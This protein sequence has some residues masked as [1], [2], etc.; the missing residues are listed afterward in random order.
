MA[1]LTSDSYLRRWLTGRNWDV[2]HTRSC[3][4]KHAAWRVKTMPNGY[5][6][7]VGPGTGW[8]SAARSAHTGNTPLEHPKGQQLPVRNQSAN[9]NAA[10]CQQVAFAARADLLTVSCT[11]CRLFFPL[12]QTRRRSC[13]VWMC[14]GGPLPSHKCAGTWSRTPVL[15][16]WLCIHV[17]SSMPW[18]A[19]PN[20]LQ[21]LDAGV[22][23]L[24]CSRPA[25]Q[26]LP[27]KAM[28]PSACHQ[29]CSSICQGKLLQDCA[30]WC[31]ESCWLCAIDE[32][33]QGLELY[34]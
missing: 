13:K 9:A 26:H 19:T 10:H 2:P 34:C 12:W 5:I 31:C 1:E 21:L 22:K 6:D 11:V 15:M 3:I 29:S 28:A 16:K 27:V 23:A 30:T 8:L 25:L 18:Y 4:L 7:E 14:L 20:S 17:T 33:T 24:I 32:A